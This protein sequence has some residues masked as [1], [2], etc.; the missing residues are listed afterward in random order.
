MPEESLRRLDYTAERIG[1]S[2]SF[3]RM[4]IRTNELVAC[5]VRGRLRVPESSIQEYI[6]RAKQGQ[7]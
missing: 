3:V 1:A 4:L 5:R 6:T 2:E 7:A